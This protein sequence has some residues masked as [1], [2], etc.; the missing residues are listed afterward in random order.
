MMRALFALA[1]LTLAGAGCRQKAPEPAAPPPVE[2]PDEEARRPHGGAQTVAPAP[3]RAP[4]DF[5]LRVYEPFFP[6]D[7]E[8]HG[9]TW[10]EIFDEPGESFEA[11]ISGYAWST[12]IRSIR[13]YPMGKPSKHLA[14]AIGIMRD[15]LSIA[16]SSQVKVM[17]HLDP[18]TGAYNTHFNQYDA[19]TV[20]N[21]MMYNKDIE[22]IHHLNIAVTETDMYAGRLNFVFG[23][24]DYVSHVGI[25]SLARL[26]GQKDP[27]IFNRRLLKLVRHE[28]GH[29][30][31][32]AHCT[33]AECVM[34]GANSRAETARTATNPSMSSIAR[35][36]AA[37]S[38]AASRGR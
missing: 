8:Y 10:N 31:G 14:G 2:R 34:R 5:P 32:M 36:S 38:R 29:M 7:H 18:P 28:I 11:Y 25:I 15:Y 6:G 3:D 20:L 13:I 35:I 16:F 17:G 33:N 27:S 21:G 1:I 23:Y 37:S 12:A 22:R 4:A 30:Y 26:G 24:A 19:N 9:V